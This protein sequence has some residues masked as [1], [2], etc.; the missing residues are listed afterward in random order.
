MMC[1]FDGK[2]HP[3]GDVI[4]LASVARQIQLIPKYGKTVDRRLTLDNSADIVPSYY[5]NSF[6]DKQS[7]Q[8]VY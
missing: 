3:S 5:L 6:L 8:A 2:E 4:E 7:Y 1:R